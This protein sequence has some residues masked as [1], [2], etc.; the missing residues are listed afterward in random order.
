MSLVDWMKQVIWAV[1]YNHLQK[2]KNNYVCMD[3]CIYICMCD[4][5]VVKYCEFYS[6]EILVPFLKN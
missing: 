2:G 4:G 5:V 6:E 3:V 1:E